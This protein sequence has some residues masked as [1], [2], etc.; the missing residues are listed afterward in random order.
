MAQ[1]TVNY[2]EQKLHREAYVMKDQFE[3]RK[4]RKYH[5]LQRRLI[6][7]LQKLGCYAVGETE[8]YTTHQIDTVD[9]VANLCKQ[10]S[11]LLELY[12]ME[13]ERVLIGNDAYMELTGNVALRQMTSLLGEYRSAQRTVMGMRITVIPW[14]NGIL[15]LPKEL[16]QTPPF[17]Q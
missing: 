13:G 14:M 16:P 3:F 15:V 8:S 17:N 7:A 9:I 11:G 6:W 10:R 4:D 2:V 12:D 5:W 1:Y